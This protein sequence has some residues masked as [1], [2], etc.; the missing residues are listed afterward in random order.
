MWQFT[1]TRYSSLKTCYA[2]SYRLEKKT[3]APVLSMASLAVAPH[4]GQHKFEYPPWRYPLAVHKHSRRI[5]SATKKRTTPRPT[6]LRSQPTSTLFYHNCYT[7]TRDHQ[8]KT[9]L[10]DHSRKT[11]TPEGGTR[12]GTRHTRHPPPNEHG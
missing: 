10:R 5:T 9:L 6:R 11:Y 4:H 12:R 8:N 1:S 7:C 2:T 3:H